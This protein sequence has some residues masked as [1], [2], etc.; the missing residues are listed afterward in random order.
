M[1]I[2]FHRANICYISSV[3][4]RHHQTAKSCE[5]ELSWGIWPGGANFNANL[6][7]GSSLHVCQFD[8][9]KN[10]IIKGI[11]TDLLD[12]NTLQDLEF[13]IFNARSC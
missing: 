3:E 10:D 8:H 7:I 11:L 13:L 6:R 2:L 9:S 5:G 4:Q 1:Y 12:I